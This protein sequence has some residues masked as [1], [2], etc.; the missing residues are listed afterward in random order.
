MRLDEIHD[1]NTPYRL[2]ALVSSAAP[3]NCRIDRDAVWGEQARIWAY[4]D[5]PPE[6]ELLEGHMPANCNL[7]LDGCAL[8]IV[9]L[10]C[11]RGGRVQTVYARRA[12]D[13][14]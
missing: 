13:A 12:G 3:I 11:A 2:A 8:R 4:P 1:I 5:P 14:V 10:S 6:G 7:A 9:Q